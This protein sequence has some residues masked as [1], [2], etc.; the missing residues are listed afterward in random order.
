[1]DDLAAALAS[2]DPEIRNMR[3]KHRMTQRDLN[4]IKKHMKKEWC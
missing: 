1:M 4:Y 2:F 3:H